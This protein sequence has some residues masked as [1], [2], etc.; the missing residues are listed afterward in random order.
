MVG[1]ISERGGTGVRL[2]AIPDANVV[3]VGSDD[4]QQA[5]AERLA[6]MQ[7]AA[8]LVVGDVGEFA[9]SLAAAICVWIMRERRV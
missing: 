2:L 3:R 9:R 7:G 4:E 5:R 6:P 1:K 8:K